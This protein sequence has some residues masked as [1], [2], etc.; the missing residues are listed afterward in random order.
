MHGC[1]HPW[2]IPTELAMSVAMHGYSP[3]PEGSSFSNHAGTTTVRFEK[4]ATLTQTDIEL[5][6]WQ[7][8]DWFGKNA[9][10]ELAPMA[11]TGARPQAPALDEG[12]LPTKQWL[13]AAA[14][15]VTEHADRVVFQDDDAE[16]AMLQ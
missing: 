9:N 2:R 14:R 12:E 15:A 11:R 10:L 7:H 8:K 4:G 5:F 6:V 16:G 13:F 3:C 1:E